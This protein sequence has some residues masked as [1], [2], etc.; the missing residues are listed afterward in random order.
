MLKLQRKAKARKMNGSVGL[1]AVYKGFDLLNL[2]FN[3]VTIKLF[4][5]DDHEGICGSQVKVVSVPFT[6]IESGDMSE[7][8]NFKRRFGTYEFSGVEESNKFI[9]VYAL[10]KTRMSRE[11]LELRGVECGGTWEQ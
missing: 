7:S 2:S 8:E 1:V 11:W 10:R 3:K 9:E 6:N 5:S 4:I